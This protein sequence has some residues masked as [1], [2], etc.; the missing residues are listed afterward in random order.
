MYFITGNAGKFAEVQALIPNVE[1]LNIDLP[2]I[3]STDP[4]EIIEAKL[5]AA[6]AHSQSE[7]I[8]ED[9]G[10]Y[11]ES[12]HGL[13]GPLI[14][15]FLD[16]LGNSGIAELALKYPNQKAYA[17]TW[18][19]YSPRSGQNYFFEGTI[20]GSIVSPRGEG[21]GWDAIFQPDGM[22]KTF[23]E[24]SREEKNSMSMRRIAAEKL[25]EHL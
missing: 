13:P 16:A 15:W 23:G 17:T 5:A 9:T 19:G 11:I 6:Q 12:L 18:I 21:F 3:Q 14:K 20:A 10:L 4:Q 1:Q 22:N 2:E 7:Y 25:L 24:M 8:V